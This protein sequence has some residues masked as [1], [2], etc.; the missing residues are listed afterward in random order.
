ME[1]EENKNQDIVDGKYLGRGKPEVE[2]KTDDKPEVK[3][4]AK[5]EKSKPAKKKYRLLPQ[6]FGKSI[7]DTKG[8]HP[9]NGK[10]TQKTLE[11]LYERGHREKITFE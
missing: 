7:N 10:T 6:Y 8:R 4:E 3:A 2:E 9:L 11:Y 5:E 1:K